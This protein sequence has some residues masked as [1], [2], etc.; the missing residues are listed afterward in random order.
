MNSIVAG[1]VVDG[2]IRINGR[3]ID[4]S[5]CDMSGY[6]YQD[7]IFVG[8]LTAREHLL[9]TARLKMSG[10]WTVH[11]QNLRVQELLTDL[12]LTKCQNVIIGEPGVTKGLSGGERKRLSFASQVIIKLG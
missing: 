8:S 2:E 11:E 12:G 4:R 3:L 10:N 5:F 1:V 9:F 7:D 6:V